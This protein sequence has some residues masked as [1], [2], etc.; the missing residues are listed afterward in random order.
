MYLVFPWVVNVSGPRP[1]DSA[2]FRTVMLP[3]A[4]DEG[5]VAQSREERRRLWWNVQLEPSRG[6][7]S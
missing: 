1:G 3:D 2:S 4:R 5:D 7:T 6:A